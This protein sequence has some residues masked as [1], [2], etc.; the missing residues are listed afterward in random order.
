MRTGRTLRCDS[1]K[2]NCQEP[3]ETTCSGKRFQFTQEEDS[4]LISLVEKYGNSDWALIAS[5]MKNRN[6]R[7]C[8]ERWA[9]Y[10]NPEIK[11]GK[12][13]PEEDQLL[14]EKYNEIGPKWVKI[15]KFMNGRSEIMVKNRYQVI[16]RR[17]YKEKNPNAP[18]RFSKKGDKDDNISNRLSNYFL[19]DTRDEKEIELENQIDVFLDAFNEFSIN[20]EAISNMI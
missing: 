5:M 3:K 1:S 12:W 17:L 20:I 7:Q 15:T 10:L 14:L 4:L 9:N 8:R 19:S 18:K 2:S 13:T 11:T 16:Q 6:S